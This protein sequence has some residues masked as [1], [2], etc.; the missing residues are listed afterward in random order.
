MNEPR[1]RSIF[2]KPASRS[3]TR[4]PDQ[5]DSKGLSESDARR[6]LDP[7]DV[8]RDPVHGDIQLTRLERV[9]IDTPQF[10]RLR[11]V[12]QLGMTYVAYPGAIHTRFIHSLGTL[13]VCSELIA[14]CNK[15]A[16]TYSRVAGPDHPVPLEI[17]SYAA[18][19]ARLCALLH[20][21]AHV[22]FGHTFEKEAQIFQKDEWQDPE[23]ENLL[24]GETSRLGSE[25]R[26]FFEEQE[27]APEAADILREDIRAVLKSKGEAVIDLKYPFVHDLVGNTICADLID[28]VRRDM[29]YCG[30][31]ETCGDRYLKYIAV[32]PVRRIGPASDDSPGLRPVRVNEKAFETRLV[33][34]ESEWCHVVLMSYRYNERGLAV[35]KP[36]VFGEAIDLVRRRLAIAQKLYFHRT[37]IAA[38]AMLAEAAVSAGLSSAMDIWEFSDAEVLKYLTQSKDGRASKLASRIRDRKLLKPIYRVSYHPQDGSSSAA[39][40]WEA[41]KRFLGFKDRHT[42]VDRLETLITNA[43][44]SSADGALGCVAISCPDRKMG[45]KA[46]DMLVMSGPKADI[47]K[48]QVSEHPPTQ[49]E[50]KAIQDTHEYLW[51]LEVFIDPEIVELR[52]SNPF[53]CKLAGAIQQTIGPKNE[54]TEFKDVPGIDLAQLE[55]QY[56]IDARL[57]V[58]DPERKITKAHYEELCSVALRSSGKETDVEYT[59]VEFLK[60]TG[61][62]PGT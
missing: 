18:L 38:S 25:L 22:P 56:L 62:K 55:Q 23:R 34:G 39:S 19:L 12:N 60:S 47:R 16:E 59:I 30:L 36:D 41:Y 10:Q 21:L 57:R 13:H 48:L 5:I 58:H 42:L 43:V 37:K 61:Y 1:Q 14:T 28:Y 46:F 26:R 11:N 49:G 27:L 45:L 2:A 29:Y 6:L 32:F 8:V 24:L 31:T 20:D 9:L 33:D 52:A 51:R 50:I 54:V 44:P 7:V 40:V 35:S 3:S 17:G 4:R 15:N 53:T